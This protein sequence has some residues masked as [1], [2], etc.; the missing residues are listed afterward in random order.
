MKNFYSRIL[1]LLPSKNEIKKAISHFSKTE[2]FL[3]LGL[4]LMLFL[5]TL[6]IL[7]DIN[8][9]FMVNVPMR[10]GEI[11]E[12]IVGTPRFINPVL[13]FSDVDEDMISLIYSGLMRRSPDG[14]LIPDLASK[15]DISKDGLT[16]TFTIRND[17][18]FQDGKP[19]TADDVIFT[20]NKIKDPIIK[21]PKK[22]SWDG[23]S[24]SK[25]DEKTVRF[26][27]KQPYALFLENTTIG[28][29]PSYLWNFSP[30]EL[31]DANTNPI[32]SGPFK[33]YSVSKGTGGIIDYYELTP[34]DR[35]VLGNPYIGK[36]TLRF[37]QNEDDQI[38]ALEKGEVDQIS[39]I[40]PSKAE[41]LKEKGYRVE[42][43]TL[44]RVFGLFFNQNQNQIF[45]DKN[46]ISAM[47]L[48]IDKDKII[49][50]VLSGYGISIDD[51]IPS[52]MI[53]Y[54]KLNKVGND[55]SYEDKVSKAENILSKDG[56]KKGD[57]GFLQKTVTEKKKKKTIN[58]E[59]SISTGN[60]PELAESASIIKDEL[61][62]I[63]MNVTVKTFDIGNLNQ[64]VIRPRKYDS[65]LFGEII[66]RETDLFAFWHSSQR[67]DPG[68]N[69]S[70]YTNSKV[71]KILEDASVT[72][73][74]KTRNAK[75][76]QFEDEV[77]KDMPAIFLYSPDFVYVVSK[78]IKG[79]SLDKII[80]PSDR[81]LDSYDWYVKTDS[82]WK[83][84][85]KQ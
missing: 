69:V 77:R 26:T 6:F 35:F 78:D 64:G 58:L 19:V 14:T 55:M 47:S 32:G 28:I 21:S 22:G 67:K 48:V 17:A 30:L 53:N 25:V 72:I 4:A 66:N 45:T 27:L 49:K 31:N 37:Y 61:T 82:V 71:D 39:S 1:D 80:S 24:V 33:I 62:A 9:S 50:K 65:L 83:I 12:G 81:F 46:V 16:Y 84:F 2:Y 56:W 38:S 3:F 59:F 8:E 29:M 52:N 23:V 7:E 44:P 20:I 54:Q 41:F 36:L 79:F 60:V 57:N 18:Y 68:L 73:D 42:S 70:M 63:G 51:P 85:S 75:Y 13:A 5:S 34:F 11:T 74:E 10:G 43:F 40:T 15:Y 76:I